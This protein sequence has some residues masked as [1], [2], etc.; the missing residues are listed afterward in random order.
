MPPQ[1]ARLV[2]ERD[3]RPYVTSRVKTKPGQP[4]A[5]APRP[6]APQQ[7][8]P[9]NPEHLSSILK[10]ASPYA[11]EDVLLKLC[12]ASPA[13]SN[14]L[15][16]GLAPHSAAAQSMI[17]NYQKS[18]QQPKAAP[19]GQ[20]DSDD[21]YERAKKNLLGRPNV[22]GPSNS[23]HPQ[24]LQTGSSSHATPPPPRGSQSV[25]RMKQELRQALT[26]SDSDD[27][28]RLPI[29]PRTAPRPQ[30]ARTPLKHLSSMSAAANRTPN[31][32]PFA[33]KLV[34][35][36]TPTPVTKTCIQCGDPFRDEND[37]CLFHTGKK[38]RGLDGS[39][40]WD[41]CHEDLDF[42]GC[43]PGTHTTMEK[44]EEELFPQRKRRST[45][46]AGDSMPQK[47]PRNF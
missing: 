36:K 22:P 32:V 29:H 24:Q 42:P 9:I 6:V 21:L 23:R 20:E 10:T 3:P 46:P 45:S 39:I 43:Q 12:R 13:L 26:T 31:P 11:L 34:N 1:Q 14:A 18:L 27:T 5:S 33:Q 16:R 47:R 7:A 40:E 4:A 35:T 28:L 38:A 25:P 30:A 15:V 8:R 37:S 44:P 41:C 17:N 2:F 19:S